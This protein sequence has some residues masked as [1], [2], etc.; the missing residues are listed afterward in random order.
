MRITKISL[1]IFRRP[2][3][4]ARMLKT[5]KIPQK[6]EIEARAIQPLTKSF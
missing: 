3:P 5:I 4:L 6:L 1:N 2:S